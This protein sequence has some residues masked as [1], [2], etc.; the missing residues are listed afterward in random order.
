MNVKKYFLMSILLL[1]F[2]QNKGEFGLKGWI[3]ILLTV[4]AS[5]YGLAYVNQEKKIKELQQNEANGTLCCFENESDCPVH[6]GQK[7]NK[8]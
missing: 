4:A 8:K 6:G 5:G 1:A 7:I 2:Y 3:V